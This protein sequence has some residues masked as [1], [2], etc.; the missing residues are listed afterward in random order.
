MPFRR[1]GLGLGVLKIAEI[2]TLELLSN[3]AT[4]FYQAQG[5]IDFS[6]E[7]IDD[8]E[9]SKLIKNEI[10]QEYL[11]WQ[12]ETVE[13]LKKSMGPD[14]AALREWET[15]DEAMSYLA[16]VKANSR[17]FINAIRAKEAKDREKQ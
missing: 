8:P 6:A 15:W 13:I 9:S 17:L 12:K 7:K 1:A 4:L 11:K 5:M 14:F 2:R 10:H 3:A 16:R